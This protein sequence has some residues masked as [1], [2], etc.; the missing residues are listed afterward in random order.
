MSEILKQRHLFTKRYFELTDHSLKISVSKLFSSYEAEFSFEELDRRIFK[1]KSFN[2]FLLVS[3]I[4]CLIALLITAMNEANGHSQVDD[5]TFYA[6][7][8]FIFSLFLWVTRQNIICLPLY[9]KRNI[10]FFNF[11]YNQNSVQ[12]FIDNILATQKNYLLNKY[13][14]KEL[15]VSPEDI[16]NQL[17][18]LKN[19]H[20][21]DDDEFENLK[22]NLLPKNP[23]PVTGFTLKPSSN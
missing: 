5:V 8:T 17:I 19:R 20:I 6:I 14:R 21:I 12:Q 4:F 23:N 13:G 22:R 7:P 10:I 18:W 2:R 9:D 16:I 1:K 11:F 15:F 3:S